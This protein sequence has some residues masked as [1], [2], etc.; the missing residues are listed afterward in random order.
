MLLGLE[1][2]LQGDDQESKGKKR[3]LRFS[4]ARCSKAS[5]ITG[6]GSHLT[7]YGNPVVASQGFQT[8]VGREKRR[9]V[10]KTRM[11]KEV[12]KVRPNLWGCRH[13]VT[14][15]PHQ[16]GLERMAIKG[17]GES[18]WDPRSVAAS[19]L[20]PITA[21]SFSQLP[22]ENQP[23]VA[24][25]NTDPPAEKATAPGRLRRV[26]FSK[27]SLHSLPSLY[28]FHTLPSSTLVTDQGE[29][30]TQFQQ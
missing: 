1:E 27:W 7:T 11:Q 25:R 4:E 6:Q 13:D 19:R 16:R 8:C 28:T 23:Q 22:R 15:A 24:K 2:H 30:N 14:N 5:P 17:Q 3:A 26:V 10:L 20:V 18:R 29:I 9:Q 21:T 12:A